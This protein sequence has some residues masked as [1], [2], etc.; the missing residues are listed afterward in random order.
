MKEEPNHHEQR[1]VRFS[2][3]VAEV[4][5]KASEEELERLQVWEAHFAKVAE[6]AKRDQA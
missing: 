4:K 6:Q 3:Y 1:S 5:D 2:D